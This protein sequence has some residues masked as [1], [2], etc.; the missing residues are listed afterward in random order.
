MLADV[1]WWLLAMRLSLTLPALA[2]QPLEAPCAMGGA[3][4]RADLT[5]LRR[6]SAPPDW[7]S[8]CVE[9]TWACAF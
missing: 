4:I 9:R 7:H 2:L 6:R 1:G 5:G 8:A 3:G